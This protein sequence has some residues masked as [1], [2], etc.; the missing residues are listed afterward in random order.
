ME[1]MG[2]TWAA[3]PFGL[4]SASDHIVQDWDES[5]FQSPIPGSGNTPG[6]LVACLD[7]VATQRKTSSKM[8]LLF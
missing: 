2:V 6:L 3:I 7:K 4:P 1:T 8:G 5:A